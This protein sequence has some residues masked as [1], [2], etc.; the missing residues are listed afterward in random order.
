[1]YSCM[2]N[3]SNRYFFVSKEQYVLMQDGATC[4]TA[5]ASILKCEELF[6]NV[7]VDWPGNSPDLNPLEHLWSRLQQSVLKSPRPRNR[8]ELITRVQREWENITQ[9]ECSNLV[10]SF[11]QRIKACVANSGK[12]TKY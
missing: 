10:L 3:V 11:P 9:V 1:M 4:H 2:L 8:E 5:K 7:W 6:P 12:H